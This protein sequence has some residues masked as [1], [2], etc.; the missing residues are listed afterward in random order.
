MENV[1]GGDII[2]PPHEAAEVNEL[3][4]TYGGDKNKIN[5][6]IRV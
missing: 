3:I 2:L 4:R 1:A 6:P 5:D